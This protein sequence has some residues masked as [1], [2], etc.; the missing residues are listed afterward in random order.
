[1]EIRDQ[2][3]RKDLKKRD[4]DYWKGQTR[5]DGDLAK[6]LE[7]RDKA[8]QDSFVFRD[9]FWSNHIVSYNHLLKSLYYE[10]INMKK[11]RESIAPKAG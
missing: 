8:L 10:Q 7:G 11:S 3:W 9:K 5:R 4:E 2:V 1:M 6:M